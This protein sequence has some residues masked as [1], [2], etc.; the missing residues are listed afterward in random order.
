VVASKPKHLSLVLISIFLC[1]IFLSCRKDRYNNTYT[2]T[3]TIFES[4]SNPIPINN[5]Q[6]QIY[7]RDDY[8]FFGGVTG[9]KLEFETDVNGHFSLSYIPGKSTGL[10]GGS[11]NTYPLSMTGID[12]IKY[13]GLYPSWYPITG[14]KDTSLNNIY[15]YKKIQKFVRKIQFNSLLGDNDSLEVITFNAYRSAYTTIH[16][17]VTAGTLLVLDTIQL[18]V[19]NHD[20]TSGSYFT[21][22]AL[23][24]EFYQ[25]DFNMILPAGDEAYR[26]QLL[27][28]P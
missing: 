13:K 23:K 6:L 8:G 25:K 27:V 9:V 1:A 11:I 14:N 7:Q 4:S 15:L 22:S 21:S 24:K 16:G 19:E 12:T 10:A 26:A 28:Y 2:I 5:Y 17:P 3:G 20:L 18:K